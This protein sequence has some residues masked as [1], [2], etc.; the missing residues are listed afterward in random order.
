MEIVDTCRKNSQTVHT[1]TSHMLYSPALL[2]LVALL[3]LFVDLSPVPDPILLTYGQTF[4]RAL[5]CCKAL[6]A[7]VSDSWV[8]G[9]LNDLWI[10]L[11]GV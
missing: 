3:L 4:R 9:L 8:A 2:F 1:F 5:L 7:L 6:L 10:E 11:R